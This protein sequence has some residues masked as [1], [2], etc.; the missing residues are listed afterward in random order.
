MQGMGTCQFPVTTSHPEVQAFINQGIGQLHGFWYLEAERTFRHAA[1][2]DPECAIAYWG[3]AMCHRNNDKRAKDFLAQA[4]KR[5]DKVSE[6]ERMY[7]E[8]LNTY[9]NAGN[10]N[11]R[12]KARKQA[13]ID[14]LEEIIDKFPEDIE[15]KAFLTFYLWEWRSEVPSSSTRSVDAIIQ[16]VLDK[17]P[18]HP[19]HHYRIHLWDYRKATVALPSAARNGQAAPG[20]AHMWH[21]SGHIYDKTNRFHDAAWQQEASARVDHAHMMRDRVLPDEIHNYAHNNEW[22][23][24]TLMTIGRGRDA[25]SLAMNMVELPRHPRFNNVSGNGSSS[26]GRRRLAE[27]VERFELWDELLQF[28]TSEYLT[29]I[30]E[31]EEVRN[32]RLRGIALANKGDMAAI[33]P[34]LTELARRYAEKLTRRDEAVAAADK[35]A[36]DEKKDQKAIDKAI[37]DARKAHADVIG[38]IEA[39][40]AELRG[41]QALSEK[42]NDDAIRHFELAKDMPRSRQAYA[43]LAAG[44]AA[45]AEEIARAEMNSRKSNTLGHALLADVLW[46]AGKKPEAV[47]AFKQL[48]PLSSEVD[49]NVPAFSRLKPIAAEMK[50]ADDWRSPRELAKDLIERPT[51]DSLGPFRWSPTPA[52]SWSLPNA[53]GETVSLANYA[54]KPVIVIFYLGAGCV[55]CMEQLAAFNPMTKQFADA[56]ISIVAISTDDPSKLGE[57]LKPGPNGE[58]FPFPIVSNADLS[59]FKLYRAYDDFENQPLHGTYLIDG[60]GLVRWHDIGFQPFMDAKFLL[61]ESK[62]LLALPVKTDKSTEQA[63][64]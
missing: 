33:D 58:V 13:Y 55:H 37:A 50:L 8:A 53:Q 63:A 29:P 62:R 52:Q 11:D 1:A 22:L 34:I 2:L 35:K 7:I 31:V 19:V 15:V 14:A 20:I 39:A 32:L 47:A 43:Y 40:Q 57:S 51:L 10:G 42:R 59:V 5:K 46:K 45:K 36:R 24:R 4:M 41:H 60:Q 64:K 6:R 44:N 26:L 49:L 28:T 54:G 27:V 9:H 3:L 61:G 18:M 56:G 48:L 17:E 38:R 23:V 12:G 16:Q 25:M 30:G 21:M